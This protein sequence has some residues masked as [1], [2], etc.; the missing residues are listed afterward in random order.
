MVMP[1]FFSS[2]ALS[3]SSYSLTLAIFCFASTL[4]IAEVRVVLPWSTCPIVPIFMCGLS[5]LNNFGPP[6]GPG[7]AAKHR[8][9]DRFDQRDNTPVGEVVLLS[10]FTNWRLRVAP[11]LVRLDRVKINVAIVRW[12]YGCFDYKQTIMKESKLWTR[13]QTR[14]SKTS[15][16]SAFG[17][18]NV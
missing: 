14:R 10:M 4:V 18:K 7:G 15:G 9:K 13:K 1:R 17:V 5:R 2:G 11:V 16:T 3:I 8:T 12:W 6:G